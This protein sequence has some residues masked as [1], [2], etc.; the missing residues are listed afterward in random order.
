[1]SSETGKSKRGFASMSPE[2]RKE[3][4]SKGGKSAHKQGK[5]YK[6]DSQSAS[7]AG[8]IGGKSVSENREHMAEIG[9]KGGENSSLKKG[10]KLI[11]LAE[12]HSDRSQ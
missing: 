10:H 9:R 1:M 8:K 4:A 5:A 7:K 2:K 12:K 6:F 3:I 11:K